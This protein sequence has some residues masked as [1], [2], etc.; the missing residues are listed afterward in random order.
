MLENIG[1]ELYKSLIYDKRYMYILTGLKNTL[2]ISLFAVI[3]GFLLGTI[4]ALI[5]DSNEKNGNFKIL[6]TLGRWYVNVIRGTPM[7]LQL[8]IIYYVIFKSVDIS[9]VLVGIIAFG[10]NSSAYVSEIIKSGINS[11]DTLQ[12][13]S[14][15]SLGFNYSK[16]MIYVILPQAIKNILPALGNELVTLIKETS[17]AG[18]IGIVDLTKASDIIASNTYNYFFPLIITAIIY[19]ILTTTLTKILNKITGGEKH[20]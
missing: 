8:M 3:I 19:F 7:L 11:V 13:E 20:A 5:N 14:A 18:Y 4:I 6:S 16:T 10:L 1:H 9:P 12:Y 15:L 17:V 2:I